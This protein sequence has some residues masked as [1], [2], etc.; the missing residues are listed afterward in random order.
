MIDPTAGGSGAASRSVVLG[1]FWRARWII[2]GAIIVAGVGGYLLS[3]GQPSEYRAESRVVLSSSQGFDP[4]GTQSYQEPTRYVANQVSIIGSQPVLEDAAGRLDNTDAA[5]LASVLDVGASG[6]ND[7][8]TVTASAATPDAAADRA[9]AV[10]AAYE[11]HVRRTVAETAAAAEAATVDAS[12]I[13]RIRTQAAVYGDGIAVVE[14]ATPPG[15]PSAPAPLRDAFLLAV[16]AGLIAAGLALWRR[17]DPAGDDTSVEDAAGARVLGSVPV[18][19]VR[20]GAAPVVH[21]DE[22]AL[23]LVSFDYARQATP[24]PVL[25]ADVG[26]NS[27]AASVVLG[28]AVSAAAQGRRVLMVD[29]EPDQRD[30]VARSGG[31]APALPLADAEASESDVLIPVP[32]ADSGSVVWLAS[33]GSSGR[34]ALDEE[35]IQR[36]VQRL[37]GAYDLVL[38]HVGPVS[39]SPLAFAMVRHAA[40][41]VAVVGPKDAPEQLSAFR[42]RLDAA[43]RPL[44]GV[45]LAR[46]I[47]ERKGTKG[48]APVTRQ[49]ATS[50]PGVKARAD[51]REG[52]A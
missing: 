38:I 17:G 44:V 31:T 29:A 34:R 19:P 16:V 9:N 52:V 24:G 5:E 39:E 6:T 49:S 43:G 18:R 14:T 36:A 13:D 42:D 32:V 27:G 33:V 7:V 45:V 50:A 37:A 10:V 48:P 8:L 40:A 21:P 2:L 23:A 15:E 3:Q 28:L 4:L 11:D 26:W 35:T 51:V 12:V 20:R 30:L 47:R 41:V 1:A 25:V 22:H 46:R